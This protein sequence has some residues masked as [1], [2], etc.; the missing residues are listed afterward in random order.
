MDLHISIL[1]FFFF[2]FDDLIVGAPFY[3][4]NTE[5]GAV[6]VYYNLRNCNETVACRYDLKLTGPAESRFGFSMTALGDI[7]RDGYTDIAIGAPYEGI[8]AIY[9][10]LGS[11][12]GLIT[13]YSQVIC[14]V[15]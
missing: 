10:Y 8:G 2:S 3:F 4:N 6:Y 15:N 5:G 13:P 14:C 1:F 7:N 11:A 12:N 9:I